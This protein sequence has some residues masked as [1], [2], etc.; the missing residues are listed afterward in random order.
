MTS[1]RLAATLARRE[2][3]GGIRGFGVL[4][5]CLALGVAA[6]AAVGTMSHA[7]VGGLKAEG[8]TL[9]GGDIELRLQSRDFAPA[10]TTFVERSALATS[11][12]VEMR[13][14]VRPETT[15]DTRALVELK[16]VDG[17]YPLVGAVVLEPAIP[18]A[19]ALEAV[20][21]VYGAVAE[22]ALLRK[23]GVELGDKLKLGDATYELRAALNR[24]PDNV[25]S[26]IN[27]GPR[28]MVAMESVAAT[29]LVQPGSQINYYL[30]ARLA[31]DVAPWI[32]TLQAEFPKAGWRIRG[33][34]QA[35]PGVERFIER[36]ALFLT[37]VGLGA[38]LVGG[39]GVANAVR[40]H[41][42]TKTEI[43]ATLKCLGASATLIFR[44]YLLEIA[45]IAGIGIVI[46]VV[47]GAILPMIAL[48]FMGPYLPVKPVIGL[49]PESLGR[50]ALF[51]AWTAF[52]FGLWPLV[53]ARDVAPASLF[54][55]SVAPVGGAMR[56]RDTAAVVGLAVGL[57]LLVVATA[58][59]RK[60]AW[61][62]VGGSAAALIVLRLGAGVIA[63]IASRLGR[64]RWPAGRLA[65]ANLH[66]PGNV[67]AEIVVS[68]GLGFALLVALAQIEANLRNQIGERLPERAPAFFFVDI[69]PQQVAAFDSRVTAVAG[70]HGFRRVP[71]LRGRIVAIDGVPVER[72][73]IHPDS[74]WAV[75]GDRA[76]TYAAERPQDSKIVSGDWWPADYRGAPLISLDAGLA[77]GFGVEVGDLLTLNILGSDIEATIASTREI[78]WR[79]LRFDFAI[80]FAP[81]T[82][83]GA[84]HTHIAAVQAPPE[85]EA[86]VERAALDGFPN[87][88]AIR[89][90]E[91]LEAASRILD[92]VAAAVRS[93][94]MIGLVAGA[95]VLAGAIAAGRRRRT[96]DAVV[97]KVLGATRRN[98]FTAFLLE[99]GALGIISGVI[100]AA[101]GTLI[102]WG[103]VVFL[104]NT[105]WVFRPAIAATTVGVALVLTLAF[106]FVGT[107][108]ALNQKAAPYL[109]NQ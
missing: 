66:R 85:A 11:A 93:T 76:L 45:A 24:E 89:V 79:S 96:Y 92:G 12:A 37:F 65:L 82:L 31:A 53:R 43:I 86:A 29:G 50:A 61:W 101:V 18:L 3:R 14:M 35:A 64:P 104:M 78:D 84:P 39:I 81:G 22:P 42:E 17:R 44:T 20:G 59:E 15:T 67:T 47:V 46:G 77:R 71:S 28:L 41:L 99:Y 48:S 6:I 60:F 106:G 2:L 74:Q 23:L 88:S 34:D 87:I 55:G 56:W 102:A 75:N 16:A 32:E 109:R 91:A 25:A 63:H 83:E 19:R 72:A 103:V 94:A 98:L 100:A 40:A 69:Q 57:A 33:A 97:L 90:R 38:L 9:L 7:V 80:I 62:F 10:E 68:L 27:F 105:P 58:S 54:R 36:M 5:A 73:E 21:G 108:R 70:A 1:W 26:V 52:L 51:G 4:I 49:D 30:R 8:T 95:L 107:L 13:G